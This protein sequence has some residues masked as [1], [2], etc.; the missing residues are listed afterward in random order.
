MKFSCMFLNRDTDE[1]KTVP[2][3][4]TAQEVKS[5]EAV[6][7]VGKDADLYAQALALRHSY[8]EVP[9]GFLHIQPPELQQA[10]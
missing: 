6:R 1:R 9:R 3:S 7:A 10:S 8:R 2:V 4:L 5:V